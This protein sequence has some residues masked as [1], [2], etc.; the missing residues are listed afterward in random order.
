MTQIDIN[1]DEINTYITL[2]MIFQRVFLTD[3]GGMRPTHVKD[4]LKRPNSIPPYPL[5]VAEEMRN[6][7]NRLVHGNWIVT[8]KGDVEGFDPQTQ[9][10]FVIKAAELNRVWDTL[11]HNEKPFRETSGNHLCPNP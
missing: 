10:N 7:R 4:A 3:M 8:E 11:I 1:L 6:V 9:T 2:G 5:A